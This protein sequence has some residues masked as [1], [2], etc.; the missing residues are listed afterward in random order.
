MCY[1]KKR[2]KI[3][4]I[5]SNF[6]DYYDSIQQYGIDEKIVFNRICNENIN[7]NQAFLKLPEPSNEIKENTKKKVND[8]SSNLIHSVL[9]SDWNNIAYNC[10]K[11]NISFPILHHMMIV[12]NGKVINTLFITD[13]KNNQ[14][15]KKNLTPE[16]AFIELINYCENIP[17]KYMPYSINKLSDKDFNK[18]K[19]FKYNIKTYSDVDFTQ[20][21]KELNNPII[22]IHSNG[23]GYSVKKEYY[24]NLPL[25]YF[26]ILD[27]LGSIEELAQ[28][29]SYCIGNIISDNNSPPLKVDDKFRIMGH[30][31][32]LK[33]SF[34]HRK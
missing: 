1:Y 23:Y 3:M 15:I 4:K 5:I 32:D 18:Y 11:R 20:L 29:I 31:F 21:H 24:T 19:N 8:F 25:R 13:E 6:K 22:F 27:A 33:Q 30:G 10:Y 28:N 2:R 14:F 34:R 7:F 9:F 26:G 17:L 12:I 16:D